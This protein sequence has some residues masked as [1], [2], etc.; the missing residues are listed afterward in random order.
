MLSENMPC[1]CNAACLLYG[2]STESP[3]ERAR[4]TWFGWQRHWWGQ[5]FALILL[6]LKAG[7]PVPS[8]KPGL[9]ARH[10]EIFLVKWDELL[11]LGASRQAREMTVI[12]C[13]TSLG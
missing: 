10:L 1:I 5:G 12:E 2:G 13:E 7:S 9:R 11:L 8:K 4:K 3:E 6:K